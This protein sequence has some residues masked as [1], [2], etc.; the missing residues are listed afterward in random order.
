MRYAF[1]ILAFLLGKSA[2]FAQDSLH[3]IIDTPGVYTPEYWKVENKTKNKFWGNSTYLGLGVSFTKRADFDISIGRANGVSHYG[4]S[5][6]TFKTSSWGA[7]YGITKAYGEPKHSARAFYEFSFFPT[8]IVGTLGLRGDYL[9]NITD[10]Q[11]YF[12]PSAGWSFV[13]MDVLYNYSFLL[14]DNTLPNLYKHGI[15]LRFKYFYDFNK[16]EIHKK[17]GGE[18]KRF[19]H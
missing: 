18:Y 12:R 15:T 10:K 3:T 2:G 16:W 7:G 8:T 17:M 4:H 6:F 9:Y 19:S 14:A 11:H 1:I 13:F 5:I